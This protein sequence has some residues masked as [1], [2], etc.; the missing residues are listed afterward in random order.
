[1]E[2]KLQLAFGSLKAELQQSRGFP[3]ASAAVFA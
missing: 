1:L 3:P 2:F